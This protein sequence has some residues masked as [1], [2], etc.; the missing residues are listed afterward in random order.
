A[1]EE[2]VPEGMELPPPA[3]FRRMY[4]LPKTRP[5]DVLHAQAGSAAGEGERL[6]QKLGRRRRMVIVISVSLVCLVMSFWPI[7]AVWDGLR[8]HPTEKSGNQEAVNR[9]ANGDGFEN[10]R[11]AD[12]DGSR[13]QAGEGGQLAAGMLGRQVVIGSPHC[14]LRQKVVANDKT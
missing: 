12:L 1:R 9:R 5:A 2:G 8:I 3:A 6:S 14:L 11:L 4:E 10:A 7:L 13:I